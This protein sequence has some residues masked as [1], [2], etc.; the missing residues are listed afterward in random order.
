MTSRQQIQAKAHRFIVFRA[1]KLFKAAFGRW[2]T[3]DEIAE[4]VPDLAPNTIRT[5]AWEIRRAAGLG[6]PRTNHRVPI[7]RRPLVI[8]DDSPLFAGDAR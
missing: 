1:V 2:P 4:L 6:A 8:M 7:T 3:N 5:I